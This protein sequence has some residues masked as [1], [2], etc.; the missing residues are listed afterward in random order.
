[1]PSVEM[2]ASVV[3][4]AGVVVGVVCLPFASARR[5]IRVSIRVRVAPRVLEGGLVK[6]RRG[7]N[8]NEPGWLGREPRR[9]RR[10]TG[11]QRALLHTRTALELA[12]GSRWG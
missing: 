7:A 9:I 6:I 12:S 3:M 5:L 8:R 4:L 10:G 1:M 2:F 11:T